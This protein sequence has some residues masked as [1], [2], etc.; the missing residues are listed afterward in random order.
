MLAHAGPEITGPLEELAAAQVRA[1]GTG[2]YLLFWL[3]VLFSLAPRRGVESVLAVL[4]SLPVEPEGVAVR[5]IGSLFNARVGSIDVAAKLAP[6]ELR[7]LAVEFYRHVRPEDDV[8]HDTVYS[9]GAR[10][11][12]ENGRR[13]MFDALMKSSGSE[14]FS[15]K[16]A[17]AADPLF[18]RLRDRIAALAQERLAAEVDSSAWSPTEVAK[19]LSGKELPPKTSTDM[20][21]LLVDRLDDLQELM[22][23]D[24]GPRAAWAMVDDENTLRPAIARELEIAAREAYTVDQEA[25]TAD[26]KET[27]IRLRATSG[28]QATIELKV[29]EKSRSARALCD[30]IDEQL[31]KKYM[32]HRE[33]RTGCLIVTV[34]DP[35]KYWL[36]PETN[37]RIYRAEL[38]ALLQLR[39]DLVQKRLGGE[40]RVLA[41]VL[42]LAPRLS[43]ERSAVTGSR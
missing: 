2:A 34:S 1:A 25:V 39:A 41:R 43:T 4:A 22:L 13:Y 36:H 26:G 15:A 16:L 27:D 30:T 14:A 35:K 8:V 37:G 38:Q 7:R 33:A 12:A 42:D 9:A 18:E 5:I 6:D 31:V 10:D 24:T 23:R 17:V 11:Y 3:P 28:Y 29:G 32:A 21:Q 20:A 19:L 40:A